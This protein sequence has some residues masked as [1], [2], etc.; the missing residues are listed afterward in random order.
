MDYF[1]LS[2]LLNVATPFRHRDHN[3]YRIFSCPRSSITLS[4]CRGGEAKQLWSPTQLYDELKHKHL[5]T[6]VS[7]YEPP[8][9]LHFKLISK[10]IQRDGGPLYDLW[11]MTKLDLFLVTPH[12]MFHSEHRP[13][14]RSNSCGIDIYSWE[15]DMK[16]INNCHQWP[17]SYSSIPMAWV[18]QDLHHYQRGFYTNDNFS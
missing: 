13:F 4:H 12:E 1:I 6:W 3:I 11:L 7:C 16:A 14:S 17:R 15:N 10:S 9:V 8:S 18:S 2:L 5:C